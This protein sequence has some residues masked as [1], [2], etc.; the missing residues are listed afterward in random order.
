[1]NRELKQLIILSL[2]F[3]MGL[4]ITVFG[5]KDSILAGLI[6]SSIGFLGLLIELFRKPKK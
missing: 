4:I 1:M 3:V 6:L 2:F 5:V